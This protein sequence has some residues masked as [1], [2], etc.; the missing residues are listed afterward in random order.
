MEGRETGLIFLLQA[1][2]GEC[3]FS[4]KEF[5]KLEADM[6]RSKAADRS[7]QPLIPRKLYLFV[8]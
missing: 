2:T 1:K 5:S 4:F 8:F 6:D 3:G 7:R